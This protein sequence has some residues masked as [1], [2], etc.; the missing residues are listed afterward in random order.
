MENAATILLSTK[1][2]GAIDSQY[3]GSIYLANRK[4]I[5]KEYGFNKKTNFYLRSLA[6]PLQVAIMCDTDII[7]DYKFTQKELAIFCASH[8]GDIQHIKILKNILKKHHIKIKDIN[9]E[10]QIP[11]DTRHFKGKKTK[12]HNNCSAKHIMMLL[13]SQYKGFDLKNYTN[14]KHPIQQLIKKK[15]E[16]LSGQKCTK[17]SFD[18]CGT[19]L[20]AIS[21]ENIIKAYFNLIKSKKFAPILNSILKYPDIFAGYNR[22]DGE[23]IKLSKGKLF[24]KVGAGGFVIIYNLE[25][26]EIL[27]VKMTQNNNEAR[28]LITFDILNKLNW[29]DIKPI[30]YELNQKKQKVAKYCYEFK[31]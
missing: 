21:I 11:L 17:L 16:E 30:E 3:Y 9:I 18:G 20:W 4:E 25:K 7:K 19:P 12:L 1:R 28:K 26:D 14:E 2:E 31:L 29:L 5:F 8:A 15:Q 27:L 13:M 22:L 6:K 24:S 10:P 23:I